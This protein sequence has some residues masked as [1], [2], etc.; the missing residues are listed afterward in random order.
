MCKKEN[1]ILSHS[2]NHGE[3]KKEGDELKTYEMP[4]FD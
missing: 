4:P 3:R 1:P 2:D